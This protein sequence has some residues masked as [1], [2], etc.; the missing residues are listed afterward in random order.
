MWLTNLFQINYIYLFVMLIVTYTMASIRFLVTC[1][2]YYFYKNSTIRINKS[3]KHKWPCLWKCTVILRS[4]EFESHHQKEIVR[5]KTTTGFLA[6][7]IYWMITPTK[8]DKRENGYEDKRTMVS[9]SRNK[10]AFKVGSHA[11]AKLGEVAVIVLIYT[12]KHE[13]HLVRNRPQ[14]NFAPYITIGR[15]RIAEQDGE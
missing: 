12:I 14:W 3:V 1:S 10:E 15:L 13:F 9:C 6:I 7:H 11:H 2:K 5:H 4:L 8:K